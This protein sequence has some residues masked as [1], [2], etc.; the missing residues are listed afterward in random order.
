M[1]FT[2]DQVLIPPRN[3]CNLMWSKKQTSGLLLQRRA[4]HFQ[5][6]IQQL[7]EHIITAPYTSLILFLSVLTIYFLQFF[8]IVFIVQELMAY[9]DIVR[10]PRHP[11]QKHN[12]CDVMFNQIVHH[13]VIHFY[14][15]PMMYDHISTP[16]VL[17]C[18][19][20]HAIYRLNSMFSRCFLHTSLLLVFCYVI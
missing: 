18:V 12:R 6:L 5:L 10:C 9:L 16:R 11:I 8:Q 14:V 13:L 3:R 19:R 17:F 4:Y 1:Y 15:Q 20:M 7:A 2:P